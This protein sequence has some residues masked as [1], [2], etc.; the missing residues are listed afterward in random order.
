MNTKLLAKFIASMLGIFIFAGVVSPKQK[1]DPE[2]KSATVEVTSS[3]MPIVTPSPAPDPNISIV[4]VIN[5]I[6]GDTFTIEGGAVIRMIGIDT[7]ETVHP[8]KPIQCYGKEASQKTKEL[9]EG[10]EIKLEKDVSETDKYSRLLR[11]V[12]VDDIFIN[13]YLVSEGFAKS[14]SYPPDVK[15]QNKFVEAQK[16]AQEENKGLWNVSACPTATPKPIITAKPSTPKPVLNTTNYAPTTTTQTVNNTG[17]AYTCN[18]SK[19]CPNMSCSEAQYQLNT[20]G[21]GARDADDDGV[22]CDSQCQ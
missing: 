12:Y 2:V 9:L 4:K 22:A 5:V 8:S 14:S 18:C 21:C 1:A 7:P 15:Y 10:K 3:P 17:G 20:C 11:Y 6:D 19:T 16:K 13:E